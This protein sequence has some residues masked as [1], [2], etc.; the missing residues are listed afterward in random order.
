MPP[1][2]SAAAPAGPPAA[3]LAVIDTN[4]WLD[5]YVF[6]DAAAQG[7][8]RCLADGRLRPVRSDPTDAELRLVLARPAFA[9]RS[10]ALG[11][12]PLRAWEELATRIT[13]QRAAPWICRDPDDQKFLDLAYDAGAALLF[14]KDRALLS[15]ARRARGAGL[16]IRI[17][18]DYPPAE[19]GPAAIG[20]R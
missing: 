19:G 11:P 15:L 4:I 9:Q 13:P 16:A 10:A 3:P 5:L 1:E 2:R 14:T 6:A 18:R 20:Y 8:A 12:E 7:L 17:P